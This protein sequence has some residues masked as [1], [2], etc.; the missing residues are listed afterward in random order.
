MDGK[1][2]NVKA[3]Q[4]ECSSKA[5]IKPLIKRLYGDTKRRH[6]VLFKAM[7]MNSS[8]CWHLLTYIGKSTI[9]ELMSM[10]LAKKFLT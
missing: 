7:G 5:F 10:K 2:V 6:A 9:F 3:L 1:L 8:I 4:E